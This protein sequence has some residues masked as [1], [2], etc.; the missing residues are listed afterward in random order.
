MLF[1]ASHPTGGSWTCGECRGE[2]TDAYT[3]ADCHTVLCPGCAKRIAHSVPAGQRQG[4]PC[5]ESLTV[6]EVA[7]A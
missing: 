7:A 1:P 5:G 4:H 6:V 2:V 3:C